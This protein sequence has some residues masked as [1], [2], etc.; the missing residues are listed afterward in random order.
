VASSPKKAWYTAAI[1]QRDAE[2]E[3]LKAKIARIPEI[4][5]Q[6]ADARAKAQAAGIAVKARLGSS[7]GEMEPID[8]IGW[9]LCWAEY[10]RRT[11]Q[12][13][14]LGPDSLR[15]K[16][17]QHGCHWSIESFPRIDDSIGEPHRSEFL[18][19]AEALGYDPFD[20]PKDAWLLHCEPSKGA[21]ELAVIEIEKAQ[22]ASLRAQRALAQ[23]VSARQAA[24]E[25]GRQDLAQKADQEASEHEA[26]ILA[27]QRKHSECKAVIEN[28]IQR[29]Y[30]VTIEGFERF[31]QYSMPLKCH[32]AT[33]IPQKRHQ[34]LPEYKGPQEEKLLPM[35]GI[36]R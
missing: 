9:G 8:G 13:Q 35:D 33:V 6:L 26:D 19:R 4:E 21:Y 1:E 32:K 25:R 22:E 23:A 3:A 34:S 11:K 18:A 16:T 36:P 12:F 17:D 27:L 29:Y 7:F 10:W 2:I 15:S 28:S 24:I 14:L 31:E 20:P 30:L 5:A